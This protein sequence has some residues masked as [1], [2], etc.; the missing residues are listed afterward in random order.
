MFV[1]MVRP[2]TLH[3][4]IAGLCM[5]LGAASTAGTAWLMDPVVNKVFIARDASL[6]W[7][8]GA[9]SWRFRGQ[10]HLGFHPGVVIRLRRSKDRR[11]HAKS[12]VLPSRR[13]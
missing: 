3:L 5:A 8:I 4:V 2:Y 13:P 12:P 9:A 10:K 1:E 7:P 11:E 6:L